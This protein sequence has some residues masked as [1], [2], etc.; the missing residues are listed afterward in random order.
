M[1]LLPPE[2][3]LISDARQI[4]VTLDGRQ[5]GQLEAFA[6]LLEKWNR[7]FNLLSRRDL[8]RVWTRHVLDSLSVADLLRGAVADIGS[9][10]GF[11]GI[12]LAVARP[13][14]EFLLVDRNQ[15]KCRFLQQVAQALDL[16][17]V[18]VRCA[19]V[20]KLHSD[21]GGR[22]G[23]AVS[24]AVAD[25]ETMVGLAAPL[26]EPGGILVL[27]TATRGHGMAVPPGA[28]RELKQIPGL[29]RP[30]EVV[31]IEQSRVGG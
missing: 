26:L 17:N 2:R 3:R 20:A 19:D 24:R 6:E 9:G 23:T 12:P 25:P 31:I 8:E 29:E 15:R 27:L 5:A 21:L 7:H 18:S 10:G 13:E 28:R 16:V 30:H 22:F 4:G 14:L 1:S 11:P